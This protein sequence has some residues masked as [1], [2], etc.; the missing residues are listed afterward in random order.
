M[1]IK[2]EENKSD[3]AFEL[4]FKNQPQSFGVLQTNRLYE[5][6]LIKKLPRQ[7]FF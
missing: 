1:I 5:A 2:E 3:S 7:A 6:K 4:A